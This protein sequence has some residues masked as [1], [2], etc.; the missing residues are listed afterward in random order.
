MALVGQGAGIGLDDELQL[1]PS[2][3]HLWIKQLLDQAEGAFAKT[4]GR[5][6]REKNDQDRRNA[7][8]AAAIARK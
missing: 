1:Q 3:I 2:L 7:E 8:L 6:R 4:L 5:I